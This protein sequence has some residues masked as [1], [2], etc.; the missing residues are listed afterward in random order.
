MNSGL[1]LEYVNVTGTFQFMTLYENL[2][3]LK[4][5]HWQCFMH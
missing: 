3:H 2:D 5:K 4:H 1:G